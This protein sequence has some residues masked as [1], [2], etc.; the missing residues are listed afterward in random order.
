MT[1]NS[2]GSPQHGG[3]RVLPRNVK[4]LGWASLLNDVASEMVFPYLPAFLMVVLGGNKFVLGIMEGAADCVSS[5]VK[6]WSGAWSDRAR[7]RKG[8]VVFGYAVAAVSRPL[9]AVLAAPWQLLLT[10]AADRVGK[11]IRTAPR[12]VMIAD[13]ADPRL[14]G[15]AF[16]FHRAMD[17]LGAAIGPL[18]A[19]VAVWLITG[20]M[21][22]GQLDPGQFRLLFGLTLLPGLAVVALLFFGLRERQ[23]ATSA[24]GEF[25]WTLRPFDRRFRIYLLA[26]FVFTLGNSSDAFLLVRAG[27][28]GIPHG[29]LPILWCVFHVAKS[30]GNW[31]AGWFVFRVGPR[32]MILAGWGFYA[33]V[34]LAFAFAS[35]AWHIW[36]L[37][38]LYA[39]FYALT[40]PAEKTLV[41]S[42]VSPERKGLAY[43]WFN[44][45]VGIG[46]LPASLIFGAIYQGFGGVVAFSWGAALALAASLILALV[47]PERQRL[48]QDRNPAAGTLP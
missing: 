7:S 43:G 36:A 32:P 41:A 15:R 47:A 35:A 30:G 8:F 28:V 33:L 48:G 31:L 25:A 21:F 37:F 29:L 4:V 42:L 10:R 11:G 44:F 1:S 16:G 45:A 23:P 5:L 39:V 9:M 13:A 14:R 20:E 6:L 40:E 22:P 27:E 46:A 17:H 12:D 34:Y 2:A 18:A 3:E 38:L 19:L 24:R 26:L